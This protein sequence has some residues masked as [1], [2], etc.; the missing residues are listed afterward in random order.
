LNPAAAGWKCDDVNGFQAGAWKPEVDHIPK[1]SFGLSD[2]SG[3][4]RF[5]SLERNSYI[6][7]FT[8]NIMNHHNFL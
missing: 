4:G 5:D 1:P 3:F 7:K 6:W 8:V 2:L